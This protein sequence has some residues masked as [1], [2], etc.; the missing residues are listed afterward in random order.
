MMAGTLGWIME[1]PAAAAY[2]VLPVGVD[3]ITPGGG[4][5][6]SEGRVGGGGQGQLSQL[7]THGDHRL[8]QAQPHSA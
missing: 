4:G 6:G 3:T 8:P 7:L 2:A 1:A 5:G